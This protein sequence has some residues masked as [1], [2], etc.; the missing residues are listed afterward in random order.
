[1]SDAVLD[2]TAYV[3]WAVLLSL[4]P[5]PCALVP[6]PLSLCPCALCP[7]ALVPVPLPLCPVLSMSL[8][9][10]ELRM[11]VHGPD[12]RGAASLAAVHDGAGAR[13]CT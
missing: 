2:M 1:M 13:A 11:Q 3:E 9:Q 12:G 5:C 4:C 7:C 8:S 10:Y 6:V